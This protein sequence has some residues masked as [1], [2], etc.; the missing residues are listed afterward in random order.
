MKQ[1]EAQGLVALLRTAYPQAH[2]DEDNAATYV[3]FLAELVSVDAAYTAIRDLI[4]SNKFLPSIAEIND[5][6]HAK[7]MQELK[8]AEQRSLPEGPETGPP[9]AVMKMLSVLQSNTPGF[10]PPDLPSLGEGK[11]EDCGTETELVQYG[12]RKLC[13]R[14]ALARARVRYALETV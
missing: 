1:D 8:A 7:R 10:K 2:F 9:D 4:Y 11:C 13:D 6:Y 3:E 5:V 12:E 14:D